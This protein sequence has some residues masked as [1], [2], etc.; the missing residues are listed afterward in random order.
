MEINQDDGSR[1][2]LMKLVPIFATAITAIFFAA[3]WIPAHSDFV[4][5]AILALF[6]LMYLF[7]IWVHE[8][9]WNL[10]RL[11]L[12][13]SLAVALALTLHVVDDNADASLLLFP[14]VYILANFSRQLLRLSSII[15]SGVIL[16][17][18]AIDYANPAFLSTKL[19]GAA[20]LYMGVKAVNLFRE[21][22]YPNRDHLKELNEAHVQLQQAHA[23]LQETSVHAMRYAALSERS[24]LAR[25]IHDGIGHRLTSLIVQLQALEIML[26]ENPEAV[27]QSIPVML[28]IA[29]QG[30]AE[31]RMSVKDWSED[32]SGLGL[33]AL[34]GVV[35][36]S[37]AHS[38]IQF[39]FAQ[40]EALSDWTVG[41]SVV[42]YRVLQES[43]T[44]VIRHS[45]AS[46]VLVSVQERERQV[47]LTVSDNGR[48]T[49]AAPLTPGFGIRGM[50]ERCR[51]VGG[52][53]AFSQNH[54][55]GLVM[56]AVVPLEPGEDTDQRTD[57]QS[58]G[59]SNPIVSGGTSHER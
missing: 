27:R 56:E 52:T 11:V 3:Y 50:Q 16:I 7:M 20:G 13:S 42:L 15:A 58:I 53:C 40:D 46:A 34:K 30:M 51:A 36:Q 28:D 17:I 49:E 33:I 2:K 57:R 29:R 45:G 12:A 41:T 21:L 35:S 43:I 1:E 24:R 26:P 38:R 32:E 18:A 4:G 39:T 6:L 37:E 9:W 22:Y 47:I 54:P 23:E 44:N 19:T 10:T 59:Q 5:T 48:H 14:A 31:V 25:E 55:H 8:T